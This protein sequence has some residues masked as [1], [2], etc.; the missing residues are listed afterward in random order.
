LHEAWNRAATERIEIACLG[1]RGRTGTALACLAVIDGVPSR[2]AVAYV[3][4]HYSPKAV[5]T[6]WQRRFVVRFR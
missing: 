4:G 2:E 6:F 5:E 1:G 3:R